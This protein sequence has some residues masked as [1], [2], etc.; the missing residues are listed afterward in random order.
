[1]VT[2]RPRRCAGAISA[3]YTGTVAA[4]D[5]TATP[6]RMRAG[7]ITAY[8]G[9][10]ALPSAP[11]KN[12]TEQTPRTLAAQDVGQLAPDEGADHG[13]EEQG[14]DDTG[15]LHA[16]EVEILLQVRQGTRDDPRVVAEQQPAQRRD[17]RQLDQVAGTAT[18]PC[19][20]ARHSEPVLLPCP[21]T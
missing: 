7:S 5:P 2:M 12:S 15:L 16:G 13:T 1:M 20:P 18:R 11:K 19:R 8:D 4:A 3:R 9:A 6:R 10:R 21:L 17:E 14:A